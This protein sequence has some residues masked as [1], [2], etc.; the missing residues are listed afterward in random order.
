MALPESFPRSS[1]LIDVTRRR[2]NPRLR[3]AV[4]LS[5]VSVT[6]A[7]AVVGIALSF[8][9]RGALWL[10]E[11]QTVAIATLPVRELFDALRE[12][13]SPPLYYLV[14]HAWAAAFGS[15]TASVRALSGIFAVAS[16]PAI[17]LLAR[18]V[19]D[20]RTAGSAVVLLATSPFAIR[21]ATEARMYSLV[22]FLVLVGAL[23]IDGARRVPSR[24]RLA[25]VGALSAALLLT[26]YWAIYL[27]AVVLAVAAVDARRRRAAFRLPVAIAVG[28]L[29]FVPWL[30]SFVHQLRSTGAP[31]AARAN[32]GDLVDVLQGYGAPYGLDSAGWT[33]W[34]LL[35][36]LAVL[37]VFGSRRRSG[38]IELRWRRSG[39]ASAL[40]AVVA[41]TLSLALL[42]GM[43]GDSPV[44]GRYTAV[45]FPL[46]VVLAAIGLDRLSV[47]AST[48]VLALAA[49][50]GV[51]GGWDASMT[52]RTAAPRVAGE[53][54]RRASSADLVLYCPDQLGPSTSRLLRR[55]HRQG[56]FPSFAPPQRVVWE[57][58]L[59]RFRST[60]VETFAAEADAR[61]TG[62]IW[63]V[64]APSY[65]TTSETCRQLREALE[66]LRPST[67]EIVPA[68]GRFFEQAQ[69]FRMRPA[70]SSS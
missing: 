64:T 1:T 52:Q 33:L 42:A 35:A 40:G 57:H 7:V 62:D 67:R 2:E 38:A 48:V 4:R 17:W 56:T 8:V 36:G 63:F 6:A 39:A 60:D 11:A 50:S 37:G 10:D 27:V 32:L 70:R 13:G 54:D 45:V 61:T 14:L 69:L 51:L 19:G 53:I 34:L 41:G 59:D 20:R 15:S 31:W 5:L 65:M 68:D 18:R 30:P 12:D 55:D 16:L 49:V 44:T 46:V 21:Y 26:H 9:S 24:A 28:A 25:S 23:A 66:D 47:P 29:A 58:Y 3:R 22:V 43:V